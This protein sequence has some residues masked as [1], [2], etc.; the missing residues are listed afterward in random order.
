MPFNINSFKE[1]IAQYGTIQT[2]KFELYVS[3]PPILQNKV[4]NNNTVETSINE[5]TN[6]MKFRTDEVSTPGVTIFNADVNRYGI[7][8]TQKQPFSALFNEITISIIND[9]ECNVWQFWHN[10]IRGIF[11]FTSQIS[12]TNQ[13]I[14][15]IPNYKSEYKENYSSVMQLVIYDNFGRNVQNIRFYQAFPIAM[16]ENSFNWMETDELLS[17]SVNISFTEYAI[18]DTNI[19]SNFT[20]QNNVN[21]NNNILNNTIT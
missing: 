7:G 14:N 1:N 6:I 8:P 21:R 3:P 20:N 4:L 2:N 13:T 19:Q 10:W 18:E 12:N 5:I 16:R 11:E 15:K 9:S 17:V